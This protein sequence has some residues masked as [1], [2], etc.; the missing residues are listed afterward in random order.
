MVRSFDRRVES[1]F[2]I[3][4]PSCK[5]EA[6]KILSYNLLDSENSYEMQEDST[7]KRVQNTSNQFD[8]HK[9]FFESN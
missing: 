9:A 3:I 6:F 5:K 7:Y 1:L 4:D 8:I 2:K